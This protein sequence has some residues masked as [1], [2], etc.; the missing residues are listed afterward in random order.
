MTIQSLG[1]VLDAK[2]ISR[3]W[4]DFSHFLRHHPHGVD[5]GVSH[6]H[7]RYVN[8]QSGIYRGGYHAVSTCVPIM[9]STSYLFRTLYAILFTSVISA[10]A[11]V[12]QDRFHAYCGRGTFGWPKL[13]D[14]HILLENFADHGDN[15]LRFFD[16][17]QIRVDAKGSWPGIGDIAGFSRVIPVIQLPRYYTLSMYF[18]YRFPLAMRCTSWRCV[19]IVSKHLDSCNFALMSYAGGETD[20]S[21][22][23]G[24][25]WGKVNA[26]GTFMMKKCLRNVKDPSGGVVVIP[27]DES[28]AFMQQTLGQDF[29]NGILSCIS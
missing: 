26:G 17:E 3:R 25:S 7:E 23:G 18:V 13:E 2:R 9:I 12:S 27:S 1:F 5:P 8:L 15:G 20:Y 14:C 28:Y 6:D 4:H 19:L 11:I 29:L 16:E 24:T 21:G 22:L 10:A